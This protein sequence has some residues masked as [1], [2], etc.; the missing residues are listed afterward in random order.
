MGIQIYRKPL[1][2]DAVFFF[3]F[4]GPMVHS[5]RFVR[6]IRGCWTSTVSWGALKWPKWRVFP[7]TS[8]LWDAAYEDIFCYNR[9]QRASR[10]IFE[11]VCYLHEK[12]F[13]YDFILHNIWDLFL[14]FVYRSTTVTYRFLALPLHMAL[15]IWFEQSWKSGTP[16]FISGVSLLIYLQETGSDYSISPFLI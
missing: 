2:A 4:Q 12:N 15:V 11:H 13:H 14:G 5:V 7:K 6:L 10:H 9:D 8:S 3:Y 16:A 1:L